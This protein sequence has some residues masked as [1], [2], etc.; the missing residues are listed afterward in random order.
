MEIYKLDLHRLRHVDAER[1]VVRFIEDH[2]DDGSELE[3]ITGN[4]HKMQ[5]LVI[6]VLDE[7]KLT[8]HVGRRFSY[9]RGCIVTW[10]K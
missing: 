4:S 9:N 2:W 5:A 3:I 6:S 10:T 7:Y 1:S 8:Y